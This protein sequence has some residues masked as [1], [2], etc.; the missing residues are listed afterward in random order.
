ME[1]EGTGSPDLTPLKLQPYG[2]IQICLLVLLTLGYIPDELVNP[3]TE[4]S[5]TT[6]FIKTAHTWYRYH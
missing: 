5:C 4:P 1:T 6:Q 3:K 2:A